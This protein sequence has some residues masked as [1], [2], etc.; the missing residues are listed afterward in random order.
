MNR[1]GKAALTRLVKA[2]V[3]L[4]PLRDA[5]AIIRLHE[6]GVEVDQAGRGDEDALLTPCIEAGGYTFWRLSM[7]ARRFLFNEALKIVDSDE[8]AF[9][10]KVWAMTLDRRPEAFAPFAGR[11]NQVRKA[12]RQFRDTCLLSPEELVA[13]AD[14]L[15][16]PRKREDDAGAGDAEPARPSAIADALMRVYGMTLEYWVFEASEDLVGVMCARMAERARGE[17]RKAGETV[18][19]DMSTPFNRARKRLMDYE[20]ELLA[21]LGGDGHTRSTKGQSP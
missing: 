20:T 9:F 6:L 16:P 14:R 8:D 5:D 10:A 12:I 13:V 4:D 17:R 15:D 1:H 7:A 21:R 11:P 2:G 19:A 3:K 18:I